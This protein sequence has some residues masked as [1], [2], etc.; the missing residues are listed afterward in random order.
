MSYLLAGI[1]VWLLLL[2]ALRLATPLIERWLLPLHPAEASLLLWVV[3]LLPFCSAL[4]IALEL[5]SPGWSH[6][7]VSEHCHNLISSQAPGGGLEQLL[8]CG[9][10]APLVPHIPWLKSLAM[11]A[12]AL[13]S[14][15]LMYRLWRS[16]QTVQSFI[17]LADPH[18]LTNVYVLPSDEPVAFT[19]GYWRSRI[20]ISRGLIERCSEHTIHAV[21][22]HER[23]HQLRHDNLRLFIAK[24]AVLPGGWFL[25]R[26]LNRLELA[27]EQACD[28]YATRFV[29][30][31]DVATSIV[32]V[33]RL[34]KRFFESQ[35]PEAASYFC[36][37][38]IPERVKAL[39][40]YQYPEKAGWHRLL[41]LGASALVAITLLLDPLHH[42][43][44]WWH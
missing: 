39:L 26:L 3:L 19:L 15:A 22:E 10:H 14:G 44:E 20:F 28:C 38:H 40:D 13:F 18:S 30:P 42:W 9:Q 5:T 2:L 11:L 17:A 23:A 34:H 43:I 32:T 35:M 33:A 24:L 36:R 37:S 31:A 7:F 6:W 1:T 8:L 25:Q 12:A 16:Q 27:N 4:I 41:W 21:V 29:A